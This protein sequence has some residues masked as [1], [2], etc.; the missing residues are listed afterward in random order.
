MEKKRTVVCEY[1]GVGHPDRLADV[2][3]DSI[4]DEFL[5]KDK[6][7]RAGIE[8]MVKDN[9]VVIGGEINSTAT[10]DYDLVVR[11][12]FNLISYPE[13]HNLT[14]DK[15]KIVNLIGKQSDEIHNGVDISNNE[16]GAGD[17]GFMVGYATNETLNY[18]PLGHYLAK[19]ICDYLDNTVTSG[20]DVKSQVTVEYDESDKPVQVKSI[21][22]SALQK[23]SL[24][25]LSKV[26]HLFMNA[27]KE[28][29]PDIINDSTEIII[30]PCGEWFVGGPISDCGVTGRKLVVNA[31][32]GYCNIGGGA[33][34]GKDFTK[35]DRSGAYM[36]RYLAKNIVAS[37]L[38]DNA[39]VTLGY[40]IGIP[41][42]T[43][44]DIEMNRNMD[45]A[46]DLAEWLRKNVDL[47]PKG[48]IDRFNGTE[49]K[50]TMTAI[51]GHY[52]GVDFFLNSG[53]KKP[54]NK[55]Q[56]IRN[57]EILDICEN[58]KK[59]FVK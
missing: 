31:Y 17:Q 24:E 9:I 49:P 33:L 18:M 35:V 25:D 46:S 23:K 4:L 57:W 29:C 39:K 32:G 42:P 54:Q 13:N 5:R 8:V 26:V 14:P 52:G 16:I 56:K 2:I 40:M 22:V 15:I 28:C 43:S 36:A 7:V 58:I 12:V 37:G 6:N 45:I 10:I 48:I 44:I 50:N 19:K 30:N 1:V 51:G 59:E 47:T 55:S 3:A 20:P 27:L 53:D 11:N 38:C 34:S 21:L 41:E